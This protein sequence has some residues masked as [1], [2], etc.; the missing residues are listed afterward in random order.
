M[1]KEK[2]VKGRGFWWTLYVIVLSVLLIGTLAFIWGNSL[3]PETYSAE[4]SSAVYDLVQPVL[5]EIFGAGEITELILR[6]ITHGAEFFV[7]GLEFTLLMAAFGGYNFKSWAFIISEGIFVALIDETLQYFVGRGA[8]LVDVWID[9]AGVFAISLI[10]GLIG[11]IVRLC[12]KN[13]T[14]KLSE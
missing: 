10:A 1:K 8:D 4:E 2:N 5:D 12:R 14:N 7:L 6:K 9:V 3:I 11:L 13:K